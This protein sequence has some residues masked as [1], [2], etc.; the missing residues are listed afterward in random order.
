MRASG[1]KSRPPTAKDG[2]ARE[3]AAAIIRQLE[4]GTAPWTKAWEPGVVGVLP[5]NGATGHAYR[6]GNVVHL[7]AVAQLRGF[8][9]SRWFTYLQAR[10]VGAQVRGGEKGTRIELFRR[11]GERDA[12][13]SQEEGCPARQGEAEATT[14]R[15]ERLLRRH[16]TVFN[17]EQ[18]EGV[19]PLTARP[20]APEWER[21]DQAESLLK[22]SG[23][24]IRHVAGDHAYYSVDEDCIVVPS[25]TQFSTSDG[26]YGTVLHE[27]AH[28]TGHPSRL[29][30]K[31]GRH[32]FGS[33]EYARE[34]LRAEIASFML[35]SELGM[36]H[37]PGPHAAY[38]ESW[39]RALK[40]DPEEILRASSDAQK[41]VDYLKEFSS[42]A[43]EAPPSFKWP[44]ERQKSQPTI[45]FDAR[46][47][48]GQ[49]LR[50]SR[51]RVPGGLDG[52]AAPSVDRPAS[53]TPGE[54]RTEPLHRREPGSGYSV[55]ESPNGHHPALRR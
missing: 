37:D 16:Y 13:G 25:R 4:A 49:G 28:W 33:E 53:W 5:K 32:P 46:P 43:T 19:A 9:D 52:E 35:G 21:F 2:Y 7:L 47:S 14:R 24:Q 39:I 17:A 15:R 27:L 55:P 40:R 11:P 34:E 42:P 6:G 1:P 12:A 51:P 50:T 22:E 26:Y 45:S 23:A 20:L 18:I 3:V 30:R 10:R 36:G 54:T 38:V 31:L 48:L 8:S 41:M 44:E 29:S